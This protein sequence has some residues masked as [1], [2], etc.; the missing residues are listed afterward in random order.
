MSSGVPR[1]SISGPL[2]SFIYSNDITEVVNNSK[3]VFYADNTTY[4]LQLT[5][6]FWLISSNNLIAGFTVLGKWPQLNAEI[7]QTL[8]F[9]RNYLITPQC[10]S[11][12]L[13]SFSNVVSSA[14]FLGVGLEIDSIFT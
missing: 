1:G 4:V 2:P 7:T 11:T 8:T 14:R 9:H 10:D 5:Y 3:V 6:D 12:F 13:P